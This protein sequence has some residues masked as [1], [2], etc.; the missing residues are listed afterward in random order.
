MWGSRLSHTPGRPG[1]VGVFA[2]MGD[3][4]GA[5]L[6]VEGA[7]VYLLYL[8]FPKVTSVNDSSFALMAFAI[9]AAGCYFQVLLPWVGA[10][11]SS[12]RVK[13]CLQVVGCAGVPKSTGPASILNG[14]QPTLH[15]LKLKELPMFPSSRWNT[16]PVR[17]PSIR[18]MLW[19]LWCPW[20]KRT[21]G[22]RPRQRGT[23]VCCAWR[24]RCETG[25]CML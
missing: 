11:E 5:G 23:S 20:C 10:E 8:G 22:A 17:K 1:V 2:K 24:Q 15:I 13:A 7:R 16:W 12:K 9:H 18:S 21:S 4:L 19:H 3:G 25:R 14:L 6:D